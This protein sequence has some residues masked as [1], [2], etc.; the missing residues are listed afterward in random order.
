MDVKLLPATCVVAGF[1]SLPAASHAADAGLDLLSP[2]P[3]SEW[4][5]TLGSSVQVSPK[6]EGASVAGLGGMPSLSWR[7]VGEPADFSAPDDSFDLA[8]YST[9]QFELGPVL[10]FKGGRYTGS[11]YRLFGL[12]DVPW[13]IEAGLYLEFWPILDKLR[14]RL[15]V[16][17]GFHGNH[18]I[19]ADLSADWV[20]RIDRFTLSGGPRL[21]FANASFMQTT[22]GVRPFE[23]VNSRFTPFDPNGGLKSIGLASALGYD[24]SANWAST[25]F[26]RY[27]RL[28]GDAA[29]SPITRNVGQRNQLT[30]GVGL[31]FS[32]TIKRN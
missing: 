31:N 28:V 8:L 13:T 20:E 7:R 30:L 16:R 15:E 6:Y 4:I 21:S 23:A 3:A 17:Q 11:D 5:V 26:M 2:T 14:T 9:R 24:W 1:L 27:D 25:V 19:V 32:F 18:G 10:N 29:A 22:F 12:K